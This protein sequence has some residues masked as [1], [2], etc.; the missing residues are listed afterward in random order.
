M[1][2]EVGETSETVSCTQIMKYFLKVHVCIIV[3]YDIN[4]LFMRDFESLQL[5]KMVQYTF[6]F[7]LVKNMTKSFIILPFSS[8]M[9]YVVYLAIYI[10]IFSLCTL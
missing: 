3:F 2:E 5:Y 1:G 6:I 10:I 8:K 7:G 4:Q 9:L